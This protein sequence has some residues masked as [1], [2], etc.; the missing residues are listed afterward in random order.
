MYVRR[1]QMLAGIGMLAVTSLALV[2][3][4]MQKGPNSGDPL[5]NGF[6]DTALA[7]V[8]DAVDQIVGKRGYM[9]HDMRPRI[10]GQ[11]V[12]RAVT[13][14]LRPAPSEK[15]T[16]AL[17]VK[18]AVEMI[19]GAGPGEVGVIVVENGLDVTGLGGLMATTAKARG[20]AGMV[21]DGAVRD[22]PEIRALDLP[23]YARSVVPST[24]VGRYASVA[25]GVPVECAGVTVNP[26]D[27]IVAGE[28]GVV[29]VPYRN[30]PAVLKRAQEID[31]RE[32]KMIPLIR[33]YK[34]LQMVVEMFNR[35]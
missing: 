21:I 10:S 22:L 2:S 9:S 30:A 8:S 5:L 25:K 11:V 35:I 15:S 3:Q 29:V 20:M 34:S 28:D 27:I 17:A 19:D 13:A 16:P 32:S 12:G 31:Q 4:A 14:L 23:V 33:K 6:K 18:H 24:A 7:S 1:K 26:G